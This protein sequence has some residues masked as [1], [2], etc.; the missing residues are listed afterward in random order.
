MQASENARARSLVETLLEA[1]VD[2]R[3][4]VDPALLE[5]ERSLQR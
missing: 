3:L 2:V 4:G 5:R 1:E